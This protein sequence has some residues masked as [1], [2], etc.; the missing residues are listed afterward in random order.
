MIT[1][2]QNKES[3]RSMQKRKVITILSVNVGNEHMC[4][5]LLQWNTQTFLFYFQLHDTNT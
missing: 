4:V 3:W 1:A 5:S 2:K